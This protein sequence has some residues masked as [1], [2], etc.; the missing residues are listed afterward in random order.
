MNDSGAAEVAWVKLDDDKRI[1]QVAVRANASANWEPPQ[2]LSTPT[3]IEVF[4]PFVAGDGAASVIWKIRD[5]NG[6]NQFFFSKKAK[7]S[8]WSPTE[9]IDIENYPKIRD[10]NFDHRGNPFILASPK[11]ERE[12]SSFHVDGNQKSLNEHAVITASPKPINLPQIIKNKEGEI[13]ALWIDRIQTTWWYG[14][15]VFDYQF[16]FSRYKDPKNWDPYTLIKS[17]MGIES[18][19][20][21]LAS[22]ISASMNQKKDLAIIWSHFNSAASKHHLKSIV[23]PGAAM[24]GEI[25]AT[26]DGFANSAIA[27]DDAGN[28]VAAWIQTFENKRVVHAAFKP[29]GQEWRGVPKRLSNSNK[30]ADHLQIDYTAAGFVVVWGEEEKK[31]KDQFK[32][33][34]HGSTFKPKAEKPDWT[35]SQQLSPIDQNCWYPSIVFSKDTGI[36]SWTTH[37]KRSQDFHIDVAT[38]TMD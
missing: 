17:L 16:A 13:A 19:T 3:N 23:W 6:N 14:T 22:D 18:A 2:S 11:D 20:S 8:S 4:I 5:Q 31:D 10:V 1:L 34:I 25:T 36:I 37:K 33:S 32:R 7:S 26:E 15:E 28:A 24:V 29:S 30:D 9:H 21:D 27:L 38:L 35:P 12:T